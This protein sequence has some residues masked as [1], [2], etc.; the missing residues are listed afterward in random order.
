MKGLRDFQIDIFSLSHKLHEFEFN[1]D[2]R[3]FSQF[4][5]SIVDHG[6]GKCYLELTK[7]ETMM[8]LNF[9]IDAS[10]ELIC[11]RSLDSFD[12][13]IKIDEKVIIKF[14]EDN[15]SLSED[16]IVI[17]QDTA[18]INI[19][20]F[21]YEFITLAVPLKKLHPRF[22]DELEEDDEP[23]MIYTSQ[24]EEETDDSQETDPRWEALKK[25]KGK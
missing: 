21:I 4:E 10:V 14:G 20:E 24:D 18:S 3:L 7:S 16:V 6:K 15:Y 9:Q 22:E 19:G 8:T 5:H 1:I 17:K 12:Y 2:D 13:P 11:D 23:E 25:L